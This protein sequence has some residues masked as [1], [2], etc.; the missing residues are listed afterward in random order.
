M[1][2]GASPMTRSEV[3]NSTKT[4]NGPLVVFNVPSLLVMV[5]QLHI[6]FP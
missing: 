1:G 4:R 6:P 2:P 3:P 5:T